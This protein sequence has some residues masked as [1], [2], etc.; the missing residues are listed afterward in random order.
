[1]TDTIRFLLGDEQREVRGV[2]PA[3]TVLEYLRQVEHR[4]GTKEGCAEG[5]CGACT[6]VVGE[7]HNGGVRYRSVNSC[8]QLLPFV[9]GKQVLTVEDLKQADGSLHPVQQAMVDE[10][11][12]QCG[13]CTPGFVMSLYAMYLQP[14]QQ[15]PSRRQI[16]DQV[17]GNLCRCT[18]Y[19]PIVRAG[20]K[21][22]GQDRALRSDGDLTRTRL[23]QLQT[24]DA[25]QMEFEQRR[26][27]AP[28]TVAGLCE[29]LDQH[30]DACIIA[31][32]TDVG[33]WI[34]KDL[35][36]LQTIIYIGNIDELKYLT[37]D[38]DQGLIRI[39]AGTTYSDAMATIS[40]H[41]PGFSTLLRRLGAVQ[42]R[43]TGTLAGNIANGSPIGDM[44]PGLIAAGS[45]IIVRS[46][47]GSR[48]LALED[49]F[50]DYGKQDLAVNEFV[51]A[52]LLPL[53][54]PASQFRTYK[55]CK[56]FD[57]DISAVCAAFSLT[58][59]NGRVDRVRIAYGG[60]A[61]TPKQASHCEA[62]LKGQAWDQATVDKARQALEQDFTPI[63][64]LR[65]S[66]DYRLLSAKNLLQ[67]F[68]LETRTLDYPVRLS[69][70]PE[71]AYVE[72]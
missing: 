13:F 3:I 37:V 67:R 68:F 63:S 42:V 44:P 69:G 51:E 4:T 46:K 43:N 20:V 50:I 48:T 16:N 57:Q 47:T 12:S 32:A 21:V 53:P 28:K 72:E 62:A 17:A 55:I 38:K 49:F 30:P 59:D 61:A 52:I 41:Y 66:R 40:H 36:V 60:M 22:L 8:I 31:G 34:T 15:T 2:D 29:L 27:Y 58:L 19:A 26:Y 65:A 14:D 11:G 9:D 35:E 10:D 54:D 23:E 5:D 18:G 71:P 64:D 33:L 7:L 56:R 45:K 70:Q 1:M 24:A 6:V 39:G 25:L